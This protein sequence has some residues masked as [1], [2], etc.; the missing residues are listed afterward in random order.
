M[1]AAPWRASKP[2]MLLPSGAVLTFDAW[3]K[4][5]LNLLAV[6]GPVEH[7]LIAIDQSVMG[8]SLPRKTEIKS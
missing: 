1:D 2:T 5:K 7:V 4:E 6:G 3:A 8:I